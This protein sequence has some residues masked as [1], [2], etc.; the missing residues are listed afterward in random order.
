MIEISFGAAP[1]SPDPNLCAFRSV[2]KRNT[3][4]L[5]PARDLNKSLLFQSL[6][7]NIGTTAG[8]PFA[9]SIRI[10][11]SSCLGMVMLALGL[12]PL[13]LAAQRS[14]T[15]AQGT[16]TTRAGSSLP[17]SGG[18]IAGPLKPSGNFS[19][20]SQIAT[21]HDALT[22]NLPLG[23][24]T[25]TGIRKGDAADVSGSVAAGDT[26]F[27]SMTGKDVRS[28]GA[29]GDSVTDDTAAVNA[30]L[31]DVCTNGGTLIIP[32]LTFKIS[33]Q[34][35]MSGCAQPWRIAGA[36]RKATLAFQ[37]QNMGLHIANDTARGSIEHLTF[38]GTSGQAVYLYNV[39][40]LTFYKNP[41]TGGGS[42]VPAGG[43]QAGL[44]VQ[45][46]ADITIEENTFTGNGPTT[47]S[48]CKN[49]SGSPA[50]CPAGYDFVANFFYFA[51]NS[52]TST[53]ERL[54][55]IR[56]R[57]YGSNTT[58][59][60]A[61]FN[62]PDSEITGNDVDQN[63]AYLNDTTAHAMSGQG[64]GINVYGNA[65]VGGSSNNW[66]STVLS[67]NV[68]T[69]TMKS[70]SVVPYAPGQ[71]VCANAKLGTSY[72]TDLG[73]CYP[74]TGVSGSG[75]STPIFTW[76]KVGTNDSTFQIDIV[77]AVPRTTI[78]GNHVTDT[79]G[80]CIYAQSMI[81][82]H[83]DENVV[84]KCARMLPTTS[85]PMSGITVSGA[86]RLTVSNN[87]I[88]TAVSLNPNTIS[89]QT[90]IPHGIGAA[91]SYDSAYIGNTITNFSGDG[92]LLGQGRLNTVAGN[93]IDGGSVGNSGIYTA[94]GAAVNLLTVSHNTIHRTTYAGIGT[95]GIVPNGYG[96][97]LVISDNIIGGNTPSAPMSYCIQ[98]VYG[99]TAANVTGNSCDGFGESSVASGRTM[100]EGI[101]DDAQA[102]QITGNTVANVS[103]YS[104]L[105]AGTDGQLSNNTGYN[106]N[107]SFAASGS[108]RA[109]VYGN[110]FGTYSSMS[111]IGI[112][113]NSDTLHWGN[114][115]TDGPKQGTCTL[116]AGTCTVST[117]E[118]QTW[119]RVLLSRQSADGITG[120]LSIGAVTANRSFVIHSS[121]SSDTSTVFWEIV[122]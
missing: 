19:A 37:G 46:G 11:L 64:Y 38:G 84:S 6:T 96:R 59:S 17:S 87:T 12:L 65:H 49:S 4:R 8:I 102:T 30:A 44:W 120:N 72:N 78:N 75:G 58:I 80:A 47:G 31:A 117:H 24:A 69:T 66:V 118:V 74:I 85:I 79:A 68:V 113:W 36:G 70:G 116:T 67:G 62:T 83:V 2:L 29:K 48:A 103:D 53:T 90:Y 14:S 101:S 33:G 34:L 16:I 50:P 100:H 93:T 20:G 32:N 98:L 110:N 97:G 9:R 45:G 57:V 10:F 61:A 86:T 109:R 73:G 52:A 95:G 82:G 42:I 94:P 91:L 35:S 5:P 51:A 60:M 122:H 71:W 1:I 106:N 119:S 99:F 18:G 28:Y 121:V 21:R 107:N 112:V 23:A 89:G 22:S 63:N 76:A 13:P 108:R 92:I 115:F 56:N 39:Q 7:G 105:E 26:V 27:E 111:G 114:Q 55:L 88:N 25:D 40:S 43:P 54:K 104:Y 41:I 77:N 3:R 15:L 81:D